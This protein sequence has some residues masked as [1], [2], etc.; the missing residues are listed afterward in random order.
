MKEPLTPAVLYILLALSEEDLHGYGIML[1][2]ETISEGAVK[3]G[4]GTLYGTIKRL[5]AAGFVEELATDE[6]DRRRIYRLTGP[7]R[8]LLRAELER[9]RRIVEL[10]AAARMAGGAL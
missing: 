5:L 4:P 9:L 2:V 8:K 7:G 3:M 1:V 6:A 10:P